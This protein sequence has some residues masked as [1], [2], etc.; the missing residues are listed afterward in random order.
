MLCVWPVL[1]AQA[2]IYTTEP[3]AA[4]LNGWSNNAPGSTAN[5]TWNGG[6]ARGIFNTDP[7]PNS[8][9]I[10]RATT[11]ASG[12][13]FVGNYL[14]G[15]VTLLGFDFLAEQLNPSLVK[16]EIYRGAEQVDAWFTEFGPTN[17]W[18]RFAVSLAG[19]ALGGWMT[20]NDQESEFQQV[21]ESV[22]EVRIYLQRGGVLPYNVTYRIDNVFINRL[23][24]GADGGWTGGEAEWRWS[25]LRTGRQYRV[26]ATTNL[27][28]NAWATVTNFVATNTVQAI[29]LTGL[30]NHPARLFR[31]IL[32]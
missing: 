28:G 18:N 24:A 12:G 31:L 25:E 16:V 4:N 22:S 11:N 7:V 23:H 5:W 3:F 2:Q 17:V 26:E 14:D 32:E 27:M 21:L 10:L 6:T 15:D 8:V 29:P 20:A 30:T 19:R 1:V 9:L 13:A